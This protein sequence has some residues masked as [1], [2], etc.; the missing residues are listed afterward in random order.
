MY[1]PVPLRVV[2]ESA[3]ALFAGGDAEAEA[4]R[5]DEAAGVD[6]V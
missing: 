3:E 1:V 2:L 4:V 6:L 5:V